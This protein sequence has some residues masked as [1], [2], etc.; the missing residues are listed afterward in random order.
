MTITQNDL[1][2]EV[3]ELIRIGIEAGQVMPPSWIVN[4][5][6]GRHALIDGDDVDFYR[7]CAFG[8][9][10]DTVRRVLRDFKGDKPETPAQLRLP[11]YEHL[12]KAYLVEREDEQQIVPLS[13]CT[14]DELENKIAEYQ[15]M[16]AGCL[17]HADELRRY[18]D[19]RQ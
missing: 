16:A 5:I 19:S 14:R 13:M 3:D 7:L 12:Q 8:H 2:T 17:L 11:G 15:S 10:R 9:V 4:E 1:Q 6:V 18:L